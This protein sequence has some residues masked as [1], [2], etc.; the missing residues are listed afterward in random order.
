M[1]YRKN[2]TSNK[3]KYSAAEKRAYWIGVGTTLFDDDPR[4]KQ[5]FVDFKQNQSKREF[6]SYQAG[7]MASMRNPKMFSFKKRKK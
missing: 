1:A 4:A 3:S 2:N 5:A 6:E 7:Q